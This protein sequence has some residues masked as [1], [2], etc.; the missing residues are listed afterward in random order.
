VKNLE[1]AYGTNILKSLTLSAVVKKM[2]SCIWL[3]VF[4]SFVSLSFIAL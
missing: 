1:V 4:S 2:F 3:T